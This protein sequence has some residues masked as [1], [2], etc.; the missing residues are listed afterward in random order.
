MSFS[1]VLV[2]ALCVT[3]ANAIPLASKVARADPPEPSPYP[4]GEA[5]GNEWEYVN[6]DPA[7]EADQRLLRRLHDI[8]CTGEVRSLASR[9]Y[10][11]AEEARTGT[12]AVFDLFFNVNHEDSG[13]TTADDVSDVLRIIRGDDSSS[14]SFIGPVVGEMIVDNNGECVHFLCFSPVC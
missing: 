6:F 2:A 7:N 13:D 12:N 4:L 10:T 5:C 14:A 3:A 9:G 1:K 11:A 8:I